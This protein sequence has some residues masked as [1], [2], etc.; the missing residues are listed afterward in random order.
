MTYLMDFEIEDSGFRDRFI[1]LPD[2]I[3]DWV[4]QYL[5][6]SKSNI[7]DFGCG[8]GL[9]ALGFA[10][11]YGVQ[12]VSGVDIMPEAN[13]CLAVASPTLNISSLPDNL[14]LRQIL[15]GEDIF[16][17]NNFDLIYSWSVFEHIE[18]TLLDRILTNL[19]E[20]LRRGGLLFIQIAPLYFS[21]EGSHLFHRIPKPWGHLT[22]QQSIYFDQL[23]KACESKEETQSLWSCY[24]TLNKLTIPELRRTLLRNHFEIIRE[25]STEDPH[26]ADLPANLLEIYRPEILTT[27][28][29]IFLARK[30]EKTVDSACEPNA[31]VKPVI[32]RL[33]RRLNSFLFKK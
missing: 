20:K 33:S 25:Y 4:S 21:S 5:N 19:H 29:V 12:S 30:N 3:A 9:T 26:I 24:E 16:P 13:E 23:C 17:D 8:Q 22:T 18:Q 6:L 11:R 14:L 10:L 15:P 32:H 31:D 1:H 7:L 28:Q 2:I 27:N